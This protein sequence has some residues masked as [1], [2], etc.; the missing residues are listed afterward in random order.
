MINK[1]WLKEINNLLDYGFTNLQIAKKL[2]LSPTTTYKYTKLLNRKTNSSRKRKIN[3]VILTKEQKEII[4]GSMLGDMSIYKTAK[5]YRFA[6]GQGGNHE[7]YFDH[8]TSIFN[9][10]IG[11]ISKCKRF[12]KRTKKFYNKFT[13]RFLASIEYKKFYD[14]M[15]IGERKTITRNWANLLTA[16]S[17]AYWFMDDGSRDCIFATNCFSKSEIEI[18]KDTIK[19]KFNIDSEIK[20]IC[21][22]EQWVLH[23]KFQDQR[24]F[25]NLIRPYI[26]PSM[27]YKLK[28]K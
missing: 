10:V 19:D 22:K 28:Y 18:L 1:E 12:D 11:K 13:V 4:Y 2:N 27:E 26:I 14:L 15:I 17:I 8:L 9:N 5:L 6:I 21:N 24:K 16:R 7:E 23:I 25:N 3:N 20:K